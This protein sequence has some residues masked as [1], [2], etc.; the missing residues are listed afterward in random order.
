MPPLIGF[1]AAALLVGLL[2]YGVVRLV[3]QVP[4]V[5]LVSL[6]IWLVAALGMG[7]GGGDYG[8]AVGVAGIRPM[9]TSLTQ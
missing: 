5:A 2:A 4:V 8:L 3:T 9:R 1:L 6:A 7:I